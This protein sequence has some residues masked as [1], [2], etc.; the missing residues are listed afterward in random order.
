MI[1]NVIYNI[2]NIYMYI[3]IL[4]IYIYIYIYRNT[5]K[6]HITMETELTL[7]TTF[8]NSATHYKDM[9]WFHGLCYMSEHKSVQCH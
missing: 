7:K 2:Y 3:Y 5:S 8:R 4:Y 9:H 6:V 1:I